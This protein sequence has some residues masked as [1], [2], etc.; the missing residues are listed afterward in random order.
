MEAGGAWQIAARYS[1][2]DLTDDNIAGGVS[3]EYTLGLNWHWSPYAKVQFNYIIGEINDHRP[4][5]GQTQ[6]NFQIVGTRF[7]CEF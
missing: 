2:L 6:G 4:V 1:H 3:D 7:Y 5:G